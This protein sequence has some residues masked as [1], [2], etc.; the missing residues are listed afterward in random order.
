M[1]LVASIP[2]AALLGV[3]LESPFG[4]LPYF[5]ALGHLSARACQL[6]AVRPLSVA[7]RPEAAAHLAWSGAGEHT[8][9]VLADRLL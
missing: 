8:G 9:N 7:M 1:L 4:A 3:I 6:G 5:W 2:V